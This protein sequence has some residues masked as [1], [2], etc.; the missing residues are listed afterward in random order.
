VCS[1]LRRTDSVPWATDEYGCCWL[2][3][4]SW[5]VGLGL[6]VTGFGSLVELGGFLKKKKKV[7]LG[8]GEG[9]NR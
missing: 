2:L 3:I 5:S 4:S 7:E 6:T 8:G 9:P 1:L